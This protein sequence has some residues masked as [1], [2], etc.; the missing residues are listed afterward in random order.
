MCLGRAVGL[1]WGGWAGVGWVGGWGWGGVGG[2]GG[3]G[4]GGGGHYIL[5]KGYISTCIGYSD[6]HN[7]YSCFPSYG[8]LA[9]GFFICFICLVVYLNV[10]AGYGATF[11]A[12]VL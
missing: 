1:G 9:S 6:V 11:A 12:A 10:G 7:V 4:W 5:F 8:L 3:G 2:R